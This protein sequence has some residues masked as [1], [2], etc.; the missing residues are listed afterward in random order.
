MTEWSLSD[1]IFMTSKSRVLKQ[2]RLSFVFLFYVPRFV[3][4][5]LG[6][7]FV[8]HSFVPTHKKRRATDF[9]HLAF[10]FLF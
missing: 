8:H 7:F 5:V 10:S 6:V 3:V 9:L 2:K 1:D 4:L